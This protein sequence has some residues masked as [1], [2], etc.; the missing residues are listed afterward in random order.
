MSKGKNEEQSILKIPLLTN[1]ETLVNTKI[2]F[3]QHVSC[4]QPSYGSLKE[5][6]QND[7]LLLIARQRL[8]NSN[9]FQA[10]K[11]KKEIYAKVCATE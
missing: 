5:I 6:Y 3:S 10:H 1:L 9:L 2:C 7:Q 8:P 11:I 4:L